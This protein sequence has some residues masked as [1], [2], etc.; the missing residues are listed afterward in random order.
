VSGSNSENQAGVYGTQG[1]PATANVPGSRLNGLTW[2][3]AS[4]DFW[5]FGGNGLGKAGSGGELNDLWKYSSGQ[6]TWVGGSNLGGQVGTYGTKGTAAATNQ[7][8]SR[9]AAMSW[10][11]VS[12]NFW[13]FGGESQSGVANGK[14]NDLWLYQP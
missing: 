1:T 3:D 8:G 14:L 7:P 5:L 9:E 10:V 12:G 2:I 4:G 11:D 13:M 6:W